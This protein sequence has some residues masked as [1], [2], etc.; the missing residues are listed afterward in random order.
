MQRTKIQSITFLQ[1]YIT[2][3]N[4]NFHVRSYS[5]STKW[6][7]TNI[8]DYTCDWSF[9]IRTLVGKGRRNDVIKELRYNQQATRP[10]V[11]TDNSVYKLPVTQVFIS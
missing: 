3:E 9:P 5:S 7:R 8:D 6:K 1:S 2:H 10:L 4:L 11:V